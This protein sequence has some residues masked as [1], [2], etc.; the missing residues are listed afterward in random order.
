MGMSRFVLFLKIVLQNETN[1]VTNHAQVFWHFCNYLGR[2]L[3]QGSGKVVPDR[4]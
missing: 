3:Y 4:L 2:Q 1:T